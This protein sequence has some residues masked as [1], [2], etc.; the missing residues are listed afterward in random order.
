[1]GLREAQGWLWLVS[2]VGFSYLRVTDI[3]KVLG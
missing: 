1:M 3:R 2:S